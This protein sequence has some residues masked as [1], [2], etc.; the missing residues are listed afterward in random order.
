MRRLTW[1]NALRWCLVLALLAGGGAAMARWGGWLAEPAQAATGPV[2]DDAGDELATTTFDGPMVRKRAA[3]AIHPA[4]GAD[5]GQIARELR[6]AAQRA[7][8]GTL[9]DA[10]FAVFS[11]EML[12]YLV[13]EQTLVLDEGVSVPDAEAFMRDNQPASVAFY[14]V[15]PVLVHDLTFAVVPAA[16][17]LPA[18]VATVIDREG[19]LSD[20]LNRY[21]TT[22]QRSGLTVR[23]FGAIIS[24]GQV[25]AVRQA[26]GRAA[27]VPADRVAVAANLPG[28]GVD[29]SHGIPDLTTKAS[30]HHG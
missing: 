16:G 9:T 5:R 18:D 22:V 6:A 17:V 20:S 3:V 26:L 21:R 28:P 1:G 14:L 13:P 19:V 12:E 30:G 10:T 4:K 8:L 27:H 23:Y 29:L 7:K 15:Q 11:P 2:T 25:E 24:D